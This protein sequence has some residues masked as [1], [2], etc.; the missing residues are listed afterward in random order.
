MI[1]ITFSNWRKKLK[2]LV[3]LVFL[4][5]AVALIS[6]YLL[7]AKT[8]VTGL[9]SEND[10]SPSGSLKVDSEIMKEKEEDADATWWGDLMETLKTHYKE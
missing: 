7:G 4:I 10:R 2:I 6:S 9:D 3:I 1:V 8:A 5:L